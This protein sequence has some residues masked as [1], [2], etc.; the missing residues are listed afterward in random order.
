MPVKLH[1][2]GKSSV[3]L[4]L[5]SYPLIF[6]LFS[7][8]AGIPSLVLKLKFIRVLLEDYQTDH[9]C[10]RKLFS[11]LNRTKLRSQTWVDG[12]MPWPQTLPPL[13]AQIMNFFFQIS[14]SSWKTYKNDLILR[15]AGGTERVRDCFSCPWI[16]WKIY[17]KYVPYLFA[18]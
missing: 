11:Q 5:H 13:Q 2:H 15:L 7:C 12:I 4:C 14:I 6:S 8:Y 16:N 1:W 9:T 10:S 3:N 17:V 18:V